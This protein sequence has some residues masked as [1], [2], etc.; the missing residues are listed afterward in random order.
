MHLGELSKMALKRGKE[1]PVC[2]EA[3]EQDRDV[4]G[5]WRVQLC[6]QAPK[7]LKAR[8]PE[9]HLIQWP[10]THMASLIIP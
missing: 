5:M 10:W 4:P 1:I 8:L 2:A 3:P 7:H 6:L 9:V